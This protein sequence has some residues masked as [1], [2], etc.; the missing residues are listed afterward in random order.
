MDKLQKFFKGL[1]RFKE[2]IVLVVLIGFLG[3][4]VYELFNPKPLEPP[5]QTMI[6]EADLP[7]QAPN[8]PPPDA[9]GSYYNLIHRSPFSYFSDAI[10]DGKVGES[11]EELG[12]ALLDLK[13]VSGKWRVRLKTPAVKGKWY[14][15]GEK[16]EE[17]ILEKIDPDDKSVEIYVERIA[18]TVTVRLR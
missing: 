7:E 13:Q 2:R 15:E 1:W 4:R 17:F 9:P 10:V 12:L 16:F 14:D 5:P 18:K 8:P 11:P 6:G 3:Y